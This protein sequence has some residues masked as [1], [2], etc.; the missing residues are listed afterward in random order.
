MV[1]RLLDHLHIREG[2]HTKYLC[3]NDA[4]YS[5]IIVR[6]GR[7]EQQLQSEEKKQGTHAES[8]DMSWWTIEK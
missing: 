1:V 6:F 3:I 7:N 2:S 8:L 5:N 4:L